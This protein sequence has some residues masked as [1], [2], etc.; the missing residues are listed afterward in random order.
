MKSIHPDVVSLVLN[1]ITPAVGKHIEDAAPLL[2]SLAN[3][4]YSLLLCQWRVLV[5]GNTP[6]PQLQ[7]I[8]ET[9]L[10][11]LSSPDIA[12]TKQACGFL[13]KLDQKRRLFETPFFLHSFRTQYLNVVLTL[14][15]KMFHNILRD[16]LVA[17]LFS[18]A[19]TNWDIFY[20]EFL[21]QY[22]GENCRG[23]DVSS[24]SFPKETNLNSF[25]LTIDVFINDWKRIHGV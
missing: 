22:V 15:L 23:L 8:L 18:I 14:L 12:S 11:I 19:A 10:H 7:P 17:L 25:R 24:L 2:P 5:N 3:F 6:S 20:G 13:S 1:S 21:P 4:F 16:D 9:F